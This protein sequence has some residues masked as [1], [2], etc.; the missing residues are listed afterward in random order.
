M[1]SAFFKIHVKAF[2]TQVKFKSETPLLFSLIKTEKYS[3]KKKS[4][5]SADFVKII[6][7]H[8]AHTWCHVQS[9]YIN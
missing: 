5:F 3:F 2:Y 9:G 6:E 7:L 4:F 8:V 1:K